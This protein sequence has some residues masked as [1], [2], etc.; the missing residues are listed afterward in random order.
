MINLD[1]K[2]DNSFVSSYS[3]NSI[4]DIMDILQLLPN[5]MQEITIGK[6]K[7]NEMQLS[8]IMKYIKIKNYPLL[9]EYLKYTT[10]EV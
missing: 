2:Y 9:K 10:I 1:I 3:A 8:S 5:H 7:L 4:E 6:T